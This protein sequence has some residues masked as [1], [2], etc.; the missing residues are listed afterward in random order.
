MLTTTVNNQEVHIQSDFPEGYLESGSFFHY[1]SIKVDLTSFQNQKE[2]KEV[3]QEIMSV[4]GED[5]ELQIL[6]GQLLCKCK[7]PKMTTILHCHMLGRGVEEKV[8]EIQERLKGIKIPYV[9]ELGLTSLN[10]YIM[11]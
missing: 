2:V 5:C 7:N 3:T 6:N 10:F 8:S 9:I 11:E 1:Y 4:L